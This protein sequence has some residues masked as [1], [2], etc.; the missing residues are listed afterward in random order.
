MRRT[1]PLVTL[2]LLP[3]AALGAS[4]GPDVG[5]LV[6]TDSTESPGPPAQA[7]DF[8]RLDA[9]T[10]SLGDSGTELVSLPFDFEWYGAAMSQVTVI[11]DGGLLFSGGLGDLRCPGDGG[12]WSGVAPF[13]DDLGAGTVR[14]ATAGRYPYRAF[15]VEWQSPHALVGGMGTFQAWLLEDRPEAVVQLVD[16]TFGD[17]SVDGGASAAIGAQGN[18]S[19]GLAWSCTGGLSDGSAAWFGPQGARPM[20]R[21]RNTSDLSQAWLGANAFQYAGRSLASGDLDGDGMA[22]VVVGNPDQSTAYVLLGGSSAGRGGALA[23]ADV[24]VTDPGTTG[25]GTTD[26]HLGAA[27]VVSDIDGDGLGD[28]VLG[29]PYANGTTLTRV[30]AVALMA[31]GSIGG[32]RSLA[33]SDTLLVGPDTSQAYAGWA[34]AAGDVDGDGYP[35]LVVGAP[36]HDAVAEDAGAVY[37]WM[38]GATALDTD[39]ALEDGLRWDGSETQDAAGTAVGVGDMDGDGAAEIVVG[40]PEADGGFAN[41]GLVYVLPGG[42]S[43][44]SGTLFADASLVVQG[45]AENDRAG[46]ALAVGDLDADGLA[47]LVISAPYFDDPLSGA[48]GVFVF[49]NPLSLGTGTGVSLVDADRVITGGASNANAGMAVALGDIDGDDYVDVIVGAPNMTAGA[50]GGGAVAVFTDPTAS[51]TTMGEADYG[52]LGDSTGGQ[53]GMAL[54]VSDS[55]VDHDGDGLAEL[56]VGAPYDDAAGTDSAGAAY[57]MELTPDFLDADADGF[58]AT[59]AGGIDCDDSDASVFPGAGET[60]GD[61]VDNDCDGWV[62]DL[63]VVRDLPDDWAW[64]LGE[65]LGLDTPALYDF[66]TS[67]AGADVSDLYLAE[68]LTF[69]AGGNLQAQTSVFGSLARGALGA[70]FTPDTANQLDLVF[71]SPVDAAGF[72]MLDAQG[73]FLVTTYDSTGVILDSL[74]LAM[75]A[76]GRPGGAFVGLTFSSS[77]DRVRLVGPGVGGWGLDDI[78][79]AW[80]EST[81]RDGDGWTNAEGDCD[82]TNAAV[83]PDQIEV[84][85]NGIDDNCDGVVDG[86]DVTVYTDPSAWDLDAAI[87]PELIDFETL[88]VGT[89]PTDDYADLGLN[90]DGDMVVV[91]DVDGSAPRDVHAG[92]ASGDT[93][94]L[95]FTETQPAASLWLLDAEGTVTIT[96]SLDGVDLYVAEVTTSGADLAG[97]VFVG[98]IWDLGVDTLTLTADASTLTWG[99]DDLTFSELGLDD[100][101]GDGLTEREG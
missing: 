31:G 66:E 54:A 86:G 44:A 47:D 58:V 61:L 96:G 27:I 59:E 32:D 57:G 35:D 73:S 83:N 13:G 36:S 69:S 88:T 45:E 100:A 24:V 9:T 72:W 75:A 20:A 51:P 71:S 38:G 52:L 55:T 49:I 22:E 28:L 18:A 11:A 87:L 81:D 85:G 70:E 82:D 50:T 1:R 10:L 80:A 33:D 43:L 79:L 42:S 8:D 26:S 39:A 25:T 6:F 19:T 68:G 60:A 3:L 84:L 76:D 17:A 97:G 12:A 56:W 64:D 4:G 77:V 15:A 7:L 16:V 53:L 41:S 29:A 63:V 67:T 74:P 21:V 92:Q 2:L 37:V 94:V 62:D 78:E 30:G 93:V 23:D 91:D 14:V 99:L 65:E 89:A 48:G 90:L 34:L 95:H 5:D 40:A 98:L 101:D 46:T